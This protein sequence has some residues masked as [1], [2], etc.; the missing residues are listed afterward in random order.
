MTTCTFPPASF[1]AVLALYSIIHVP[2]TEQPALL[3]AIHD[4]L[5]PGGRF[6]ATWALTAWEGREPNWQGWGAPMWWSHYDAAAS[7]AMLEAAGFAIVDARVEAS[8]G[9][10]WLW[11]LAQREDGGR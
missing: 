5:R 11:L 8:G 9:E 3:A 1:A 10:T 7:R 6:L 2:R 4:W